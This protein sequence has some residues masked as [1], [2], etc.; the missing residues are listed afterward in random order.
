MAQFQ[1]E[2]ELRVKVL[3]K[4]LADLEKR[5]A[6]VSNPFSASGAKRNDKRLAAAKQA[7]KAELDLIRQAVEAEDRL[8]ETKAQKRVQTNLRRIRFLRDE[9]I[10]AARQSEAAAAKAAKQ[11]Q[12]RIQGLQLG[13]GFPLLFGGGVGSVA[14]GALER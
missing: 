12:N 14:G 13:V 7:Q 8:R 11:R 4:E 6:K 2:I 1:S 3:D 10:K 9:R 5:I